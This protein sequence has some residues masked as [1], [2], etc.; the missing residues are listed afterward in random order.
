MIIAV[1]G[2]STLGEIS[3]GYGVLRSLQRCGGHEL[4][5]LAYDP[6]ETCLHQNGL[7]KRAYLAPFPGKDWPGYLKRLSEIKARNGLDILI[8][9]IE[10]ELPFLLDHLHDL[11]ALGIKTLLPSKRAL[12]DLSQHTFRD[13]SGKPPLSFSIP[14]ADARSERV[15]IR[16][17]GKTPVQK[18]PAIHLVEEDCFSLALLTGKDH[19]IVGLAVIKTLQTSSDGRTWMGLSIDEHDFV[20]SA[21]AITS[22]TRWVGP[23]T[24]NLT[25]NREGDIRV[26]NIHPQFPDWINF[27]AQCGANLPALL[28]DLILDRNISSRPPTSAG[29]MFIRTAIDVV[30]DI[31]CFG[32]FSLEG[33]TV[34]DDN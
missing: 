18:T 20:P 14:A 34:Y 9:G 11:N 27:A 32:I 22:R 10:R 5:G 8:P 2:L 4:I 7:M 12:A 24:I 21:E 16:S 29:K 25:R 15:T 23:M 17:F 28:I 13:V 30:T 33:E 19:T 1:T 26:E 3:T 31:E 6:F